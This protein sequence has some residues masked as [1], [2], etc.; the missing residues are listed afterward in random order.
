MDDRSTETS[1]RD[2]NDPGVAAQHAVPSRATSREVAAVARV[3]QA[4]VSNVLNRPEVVAPETLARVRAVMDAMGFI[5]N[6]SARTL[7]AGKSSTIGVIVLD[8]ANPYWGEMTRG[9]EAAASAVGQ[10][11]IVCSSDESPAKE[12]Q[13]LRLLEEQQV[14]G[15]LLAPVVADSATINAIRRRGTDLVFVDRADPTHRS[16]SVAVDHVHGAFLAGEYLI[17][18]GHRDVAFVNGPRS[19]PWCR[20]RAAGFFQAFEAADLDPAVHVH[21]I[22]MPAMTARGGADSV[23]RVCDLT[24]A[25]SA[26]FCANDML[27]LGVLKGL[28][29]RGIAVPA[30]VSLVGY[31]DDD[32]AEL[33]SPGLTTIRQDPYAIG[34]RAAQ[35]I[36]GGAPRAERESVIF[37]AVLVVRESVRHM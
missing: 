10:V 1:T 3:S 24:P 25:V 29:R 37:D 33:L 16:A 5:V 6:H 32:F 2:A 21:E 4:T 34:Q 11:V 30:D 28:T 13:F 14:C 20:D 27:A 8:V 18:M 26:I 23:G 35:L 19:V 7:R 15:I 17:A 31:D 36:L 22:T 9:I 12:D